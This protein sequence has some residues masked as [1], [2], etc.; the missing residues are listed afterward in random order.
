MF[1]LRWFTPP[2]VLALRRYHASYLPGDMVAGILVAA[3]AIP[4]ALGY[5]VVAGVPVQV[6]LYSLPPALLAYAM[7][8]SS[9]L[10]FVGPVSTIS[11]LSG[12]LVRQISGGDPTQAS[13]LTADIALVAGLVLL[14]AG[15][16]RLGW[17]A[18]FLSEPIVT[19]F[20]TG[21][22]ILIVVGEIPGL[23]GLDPPSGALVTRLLAILTHVQSAHWL[24]ALIGAGALLVLFLGSALAPRAPWALLLLIGGI[25][26]STVWNWADHGVR[27]VGEIPAGLPL[28]HL[29]LPDPSLWGDLL[30]GGLAVAGV[31]IAEGLA[32]A[33]TFGSAT[34][35]KGNQDDS[36]LI[37]NGL[38][39]MASAVFGG[40]AVAGSLSK[41]AAN[42]RAGA[43]TQLSG[44]AATLVVLAVL[45]FAT[46]T[47][48]QL[49]KVVLSAVVVHAVWG[50]VHPSEFRRFARV[51]RNDFVGAV[52]ALVGVLALGP[53]YGLLT[54]IAQSLLGLIY[55]SMQVGIDE[56]GRVR[57]EKAA[58]GAIS[59]DDSRRPVHGVCVLRPDGPLFW[60]NA[61]SVIDR[62]E[63][64]VT[65]REDVRVLVL[66]LEATNQMD[67]TSA[68]RLGKLITD[69]RANG[70][71][72]MLVRVFENVG[73]V[74]ERAGVTEEL[75]ADHVW[76]SIS[77]AVKEAK[78]IAGEPM[79]AEDETGEDEPEEHI[80]S[81]STRRRFRRS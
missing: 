30:T 57:G 58:W 5:S 1:V 75:G 64:H 19:G 4:Q 7:F 67:T 2:G 56:M 41:T 52:V 80:A 31:G 10:L 78:V 11:V 74:L 36:E 15:L 73:E 60:A 14:A 33:R 47:L 45:V 43:K 6:G 66:D 32:A 62:V 35:A 44:V 28:P 3:L 42:S 37:G 22:V 21:L 76:H 68:E 16:L 50:L 71:T 29:P 39:D 69:L 46:G 63:A 55:R 13:A 26:A 18:R 51:R 77:A 48:T 61:V 20:V 24:T 8:G 72:V 27:V 79:E 38:A 12:S 65:D 34:T 9:R 49:P 59:H 40:M 23:L 81:R 70:I 53:L 54:A 25:V 17:V